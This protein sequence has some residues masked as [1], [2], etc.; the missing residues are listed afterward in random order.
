MLTEYDQSVDV[1]VKHIAIG[2]GGVGFDPRV[3][4]FVRYRQRIATAAMFLRSCVAQALNRG[5][6]PVTHYMLRRNTASIM[7]S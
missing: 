2:A 6:G 7:K 3:G 4:Q 1:A 5:A